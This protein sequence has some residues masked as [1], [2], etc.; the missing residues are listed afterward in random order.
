MKERV[1]DICG[2][3]IPNG[4]YICPGCGNSIN[5]M[6]DNGVTVNPRSILRPGKIFGIIFISVIFFIFIITYFT[7]NQI[8][9]FM[10]EFG[11]NNIIVPSQEQN[12]YFDST[13]PYI[14]VD[15]NEF[16]VYSGMD[17]A[18]SKLG[19]IYSDEK[20]NYSLIHEQSDSTCIWYKINYVGR[21]G[22]ICDDKTDGLQITA[23]DHSQ[24]IPKVLNKN[25]E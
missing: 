10:D 1:C 6:V 23:V 18:S 24:D 9:N 4:Q 19:T 14:V 15:L 20:Y 12:S 16:A 17:I 3:N 11:N 7:I 13:L 5:E 25:N 2:N 8:G 21:D 22:F